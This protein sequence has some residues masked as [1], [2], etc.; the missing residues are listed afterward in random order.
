MFDPDDK[1][2][3]P[4]IHKRAAIGELIQTRLSRRK[5]LG[6]MV[7]SA[8]LLAS[9]SSFSAKSTDSFAFQEISRGIDG[10]HHLPAGY[11]ADILLR[12]G[13]H[14]FDDNAAEFDPYR[15]SEAEQLQRFGYNNDYIGFIPLDDSGTRALLCV[16]HE[17]TNAGMMFPGVAGNLPESLTRDHVL[18]EMAAQ[19]GSIVEIRNKNNRW[20]VVRNSPYTRRITPHRTPMQIT[21]PVAGHAR[22]KT[23]ADPTGTLAAG[24]M[25]NCAGGITP[26]GT[27][28]MAEENFNLYFLGKL[29]DDHPEAASHKRYG[30]GFPLVAWGLFEDRFQ[31]EKEP[32]EP[33]RFG[34]VVEVDPM[35]PESIPK[36]RTALGRIK[37][38]GAETVIAPDGR[39]VVYMGDDQRFDYVYKF[40]STEAFNAK[41]PNPNLLD[42]GT[43]FVARFGEDGYLDWLPLV[44][45]KGPLVEANGFFFPGRCPYRNPTRRRSAG[46]N[47]H[48]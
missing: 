6:G 30:L 39:I 47:T 2:S 42:D 26:W 45:G 36:K 37:H 4:N 16:N 20:Q 43:L 18:A 19:G 29:P 7:A 3:N 22:L 35:N 17:Y 21:G 46:R 34:W 5:V 14:L 10:N 9:P 38:E 31:V 44:Y 32:H 8:G 13:D 15:Q 40:V 33:N 28:L 25:N 27:W 24:T 12:W 1:S 41:K 48:G 23:S 11:E